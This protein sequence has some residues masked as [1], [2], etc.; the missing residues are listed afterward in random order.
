MLTRGFLE[1]HEAPTQIWQ[2]LPLGCL[3]QQR[4]LLLLAALLQPAHVRPRGSGTLAPSGSSAACPTG[5]G[6]VPCAGILDVQFINMDRSTERATNMSSVLRV[7]RA[8]D[9][10]GLVRTISRFPAVQAEC[11]EDR[12]D[13]ACEMSN[14][15]AL[16]SIEVAAIEDPLIKQRAH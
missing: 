12:A 16:S 10:A 4:M 8:R 13:L 5:L 3:S 1:G 7:A 14:R 9:A 15:S 2:P 6:R 11:T